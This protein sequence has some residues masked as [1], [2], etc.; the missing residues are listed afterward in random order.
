MAK[1]KN[2]AQKGGLT[3][4]R[5]VTGR[6]ICFSEVEILVQEQVCLRWSCKRFG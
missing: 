4:L 5:H 1:V 6:Q 3:F 2:A